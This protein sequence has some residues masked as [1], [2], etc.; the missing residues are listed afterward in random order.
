MGL[1][2]GLYKVSTTTRNGPMFVAL[3]PGPAF[4]G[5][6]VF[7]GPESWVTVVNVEPLGG[8]KYACRLWYHS[9]LNVGYDEGN[10]E[11]GARTIVSPNSDQGWAVD[12]GNND[13]CYR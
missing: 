3:P 9:G 10:M 11:P 12:P 4:V 5:S 2:Q 6:P 13:G 8:D 7:A 1:K